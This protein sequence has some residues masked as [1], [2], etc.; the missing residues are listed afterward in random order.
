MSRHRLFN[1]EVMAP[2]VGFSY[3][4]IP[5]DG[6]PLYLAGITGHLPDM[7]LP[8][9][10]IAQFA[11]ACRS[12]ALVIEEAGGGPSDLV[13]MT[14]YTTALEEYR[15]SL[16]P[17]GDAYRSVFGKHYPPMALIGVSGLFDPGAMVELVCMAVVPSDE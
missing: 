10:L 5:S 11:E 2:A 12:V 9:G 14:I 13:S 1:P 8:V 6:K 4:A 16:K 7:T 15:A 17:I 3:G